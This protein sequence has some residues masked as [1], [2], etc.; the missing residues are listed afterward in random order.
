MSD[1]KNAWPSWFRNAMNQSDHNEWNAT[2][3][4]GTRQLCEECGEIT[5]RCEE[6]SLILDNDYGPLCWACFCELGG[7]ES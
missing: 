1:S 3:F 5:E 6:D 2:N 4:P 7:G